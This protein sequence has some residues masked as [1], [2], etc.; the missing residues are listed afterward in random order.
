MLIASLGLADLMWSLLAIFFI[1]TYWM[2][3]FFVIVDVF[4][5]DAS[6]VSKAVWLL[7]LLFL[8]V[9]G[10]FSYLITHGDGMSR[11]NR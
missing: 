4:R 10:M 7:F 11:R 3:L 2:I 1:V 9:I 6:G 8:P 5:S